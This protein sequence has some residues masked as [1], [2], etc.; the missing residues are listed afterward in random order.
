MKQIASMTA[1]MSRICFECMGANISG[2]TKYYEGEDEEVAEAAKNCMWK[3]VAT[4]DGGGSWRLERS[5]EGTG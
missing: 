3:P 1:T 4:A 2:L 5:G